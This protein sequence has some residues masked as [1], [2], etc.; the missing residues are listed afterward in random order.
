[1][2]LLSEATW[3]YD[4]T[5]Y[6]LQATTVSHVGHVRARNEDRAFIEAG[7]FGVCDGMGGVGGGSLAAETASTQ[8]VRS[9]REGRSPA[10][11]IDDAHREV[12]NVA[13]SPGG[14]SGMGATLC[15]GVFGM[16][17]HRPSMALV[18]V[19]DSRAYLARDGEGLR[20][21]TRDQRWVQDQ[22][23]AGIIAPEAARDHPNRNILTSV[24][25]GLNAYDPWLDFIEPRS[26]DR[27]I[28]CTDGVSEELSDEILAAGVLAAANAEALAHE[29]LRTVLEGAARDNATLVVVAV[30][31]VP[32]TPSSSRF[33]GS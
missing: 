9:I 12:L 15:A 24:V 21:L 23:D 25:G 1:V 18:N 3:R 17:E 5:P 33:S 16:T 27:Y 2:T 13:Q 4:P 20:L 11:A 26:G 30:L 7:C 8:F 6:L 19:G 14:V 22:V 28:F 31:E 29:L 10:M 32:G